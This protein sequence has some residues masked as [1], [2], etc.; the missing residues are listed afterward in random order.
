M[1]SESKEMRQ[2]RATVKELYEKW[3]NDPHIIL[4]SQQYLFDKEVSR[5]QNLSRDNLV[6]WINSVTLAM[7]LATA[8]KKCCN[9][10]SAQLMKEFLG[11]TNKTSQNNANEN[12]LRTCNASDN[13]LTMNI[14]VA[15]VHRRAT[16]TFRKPTFWKASFWCGHA[17][18]HFNHSIL[19]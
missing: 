5:G 16:T 15:E 10:K 9:T 19:P 3:N 4:R 11:A 18:M 12:Q 1:A 17:K 6:C 2:L 7:D 13:T 8:R 14:L